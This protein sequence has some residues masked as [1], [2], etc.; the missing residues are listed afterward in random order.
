VWVFLT[1]FAV[2][3]RSYVSTT[4][5]AIGQIAPFG[6]LIFGALAFLAFV[7]PVFAGAREDEATVSDEDSGGGGGGTRRPTPPAGPSGGATATPDPDPVAATPA[8]P[9]SSDDES[10]APEP[11]GA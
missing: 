7:A 10:S 2:V 8:D 11:V 9:A 4:D 1:G 5:D 6:A 3:V